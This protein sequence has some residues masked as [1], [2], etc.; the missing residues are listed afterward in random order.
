MKR[1]NVIGTTGSGKST[2]A[3]ALSRQL[4]YPYVQI[5]QIYWKPNWQEPADEEFLPYLE[6]AISG[7][8]WVL[9]GNYNRTNSIK[10]KQVDTIIWLDFGFIHTLFQ[11][12]VRT[13][14][15][16]SLK[17]ELW[18]GTGNRESFYRSFISSDSILVWLFRSYGKNRARYSKLMQSVDHSHIKMIRLQSPSEVRKFLRNTGNRPSQTDQARYNAKI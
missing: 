5:D 15:R 4:S 9:D 16:A 6:K 11:L 8:M 18:P 13:V 2:F 14:K 10:W 1:I 7:D 3:S 17:R 12:V